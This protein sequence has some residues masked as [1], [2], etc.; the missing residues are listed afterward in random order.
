MYAYE[1]LMQAAMWWL[2][3]FWFAAIW[4]EGAM[5][6]ALAWPFRLLD[7]LTSQNLPRPAWHAITWTL[8][9]VAVLRTFN[10]I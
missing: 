1:W 7:C 10:I 8:V 2:I 5:L 6:K 9:A 3:G 4:Y